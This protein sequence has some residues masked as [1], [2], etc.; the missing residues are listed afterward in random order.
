MEKHTL[1][2]VHI[3]DRMES[4]VSVQ[5]I[6]TEDGNLIKTRLGLHDYTE[7]ADCAAHGLIVLELVSSDAAKNQQLA[8]KLN[9]VSGV[10]AKM[11]E[12]E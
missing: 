7:G 12:L 5:K 1:M 2:G 10:T 8:A 11:M 3:N 4:A 9:D 6:L